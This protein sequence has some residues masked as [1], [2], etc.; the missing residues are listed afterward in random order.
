MPDL[1]NKY[2][3][4]RAIRLASALAMTSVWASFFDLSIYQSG[5]FF[6]ATLFLSIIDMSA[7]VNM[8][9]K[10][11]LITLISSV[12]I[13]GLTI[14]LNNY[15]YSYYVFIPVLVFVALFGA[16][17]FPVRNLFL[18]VSLFAFV[19]ALP[20]E[21]SKI[22]L[23]EFVWYQMCGGLWYF[24]TVLFGI[25]VFKLLKWRNS[26]WAEYFYLDETYASTE[27]EHF[28]TPKEELQ[29]I[30]KEENQGEV[31][32][33]FRHPFRLIVSLLVGYSYL[34]VFPSNLGYWILLTIIFLH[35]P[36]KKINASLPRI[37][38]R[39][40]GTMVGLIVIFP[41]AILQPD[42]WVWLLLTFSAAV[43]IFLFLRD[44]YF[45]AIIFITILVMAKI[46][47]VKRIDIDVLSERG[48]DTLIGIVIVLATHLILRWI[49]VALIAIRRNYH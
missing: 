45:I 20:F 22:S 2:Y 21:P 39:F 12:S 17:V 40:L 24:S 35:H 6:G 13:G 46:A 15:P 42:N 30:I 33:A 41:I 28:I 10:M 27:E 16:K 23:S 37:I 49:K 19:F 11:L 48:L 5:A 31:N 38:Q 32:F 9:L 1:S 47:T 4:W 34:V 25:S 29:K 36:S 18:S 14:F 3:F 26:K 43:P 8:R 44:N 7:S